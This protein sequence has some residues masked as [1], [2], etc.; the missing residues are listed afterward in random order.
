MARLEEKEIDIAGHWMVTDP[1][2]DSIVIEYTE[3]KVKVHENPLGVITNN[4]NYDWHMTNLR[5]Y[6]QLSKSPYPTKSIDGRK[7]EVIDLAPLGGGSGM[8]G[9]PGDMTPPS[10]FVRAVAWTQ[11]ARKMPT[12]SETI[13]EHFRILDG[14]NLALGSAEGSDQ[15]S[16]LEGMRSSTI[17]TTG[18][19]LS[20]KVLYYHTQ[21]NRRVRKV[22]VSKIDFSKKMNEITYIVLDKTKDQD[23]NDRTPQ[24]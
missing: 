11:T 21:H 24:M 4:P 14:F 12:F 8:L 17:W 7:D 16:L 19:D 15:E 2:G 5:N 23:I 10:R 20:N 6:I 9:L 3:G 1:T 13:Y 18:W 22:D